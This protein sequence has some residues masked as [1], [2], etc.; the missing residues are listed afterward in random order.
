MLFDT[1]ASH[2]FV[3][4]LFASI[5]KLEYEKLDS[6]LSVGVLLGKD[7]KLSFKCNLVCIEIKKQ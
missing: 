5:L 6:N 3:S 2:S 4:V 7:Y 1:D